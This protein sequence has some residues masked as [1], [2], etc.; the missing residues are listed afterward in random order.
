MNQSTLR[1]DLYNGIADTI[2]R[3]DFN[4]ANAGRR[5]ILPS[6]YLSGDRF[7]QQLF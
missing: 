4:A 3:E 5:V 2:L 1:A 6:S 7:M